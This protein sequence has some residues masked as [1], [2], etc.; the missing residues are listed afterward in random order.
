[1]ISALIVTA[2]VL[3]CF[4]EGFVITALDR[5][6]D[7]LRDEIGVLEEA[8]IDLCRSLAEMKKR[9][10]WNENRGA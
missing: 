9:R 8:N 6:N 7:K 4:I 1:M 5:E 3:C 2:L 10:G